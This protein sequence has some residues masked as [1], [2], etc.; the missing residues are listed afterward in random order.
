MSDKAKKRRSGRDAKYYQNQ[1]FVTERNKKRRASQR[2]RKAKSPATKQRAM[3]RDLKALAKYE[4][5]L[6]KRRQSTAKKQPVAE[7]IPF[8]QPTEQVGE[9][10]G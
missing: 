7:V 9:N 4:A 6:I 5:N 2:E 8:V 3:R 10:S 1:F